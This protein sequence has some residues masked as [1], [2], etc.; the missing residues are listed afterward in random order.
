[1]GM[2]DRQLVQDAHGV[3]DTHLHGI[4]G[5]VVR[6]VAGPQAPVVDVDPTELPGRKRLGDIRLSHIGDGVQEPA[7]KDDR[8]SVTALVLEVHPATVQPVPRARHH[9]HLFCSDSRLGDHPTP[10]RRPTPMDHSSRTV[11]TR[12]ELDCIE[13]VRPS[14]RRFRDQ[15]LTAHNDRR[16]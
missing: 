2:F 14:N 7:M 6:L 3:P 9:G 13:A 12:P 4:R 16:P 8:D 1:M 11:P 5:C 10:E 15:P